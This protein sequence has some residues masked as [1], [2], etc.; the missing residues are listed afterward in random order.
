MPT[1][2]REATETPHRETTVTVFDA[3][4]R[5]ILD[6]ALEQFCVLGIRRSSMEDV[7]RRAGVGRATLYRRFETKDDLVSALVQRETRAM[8]ATIEGILERESDPVAR[9]VLAF[10][11]GIRMTR[12]HR[13][14]GAL[15]ATE[16][17]SILPSLTLGAAT[18][19]ALVRVAMA[20]HV[21][22]A[23][24]E[25]GLPDEYAEEISELVV[26]VAHSLALTP[27]T[28]LPLDDPDGARA[29]A[30]HVIVPLVFG[31]TFRASD[32][33]SPR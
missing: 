13:L 24:A 17:D 8:V 31:R 27:E 26:R 32:E 3:S 9:I 21:R 29:F 2:P 6:S 28:A 11:N 4:I 20:E 33:R 23:R 30:H 10:T 18:G 22:R 1:R 5:R 15:L 7:A 12:Q 19:I 16:P 14:I 25:V